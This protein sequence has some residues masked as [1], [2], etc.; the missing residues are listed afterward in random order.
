MKNKIIR[1]ICSLLVFFIVL[2]VSVKGSE[3][4]SLAQVSENERSYVP[5]SVI[6]LLKSEL[7]NILQADL[8][9]KGYGDKEERAL[10]KD[11]ASAEKN[12]LKTNILMIEQNNKIIYLLQQLNEK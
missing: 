10:L 3:K 4:I 5:E 9:V 2:F 8:E 11:I 7:E 12:I 1:C 6:I